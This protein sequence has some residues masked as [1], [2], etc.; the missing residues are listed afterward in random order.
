MTPNLSCLSSPAASVLAQIPESFKLSA[1]YSL[2]FCFFLL[3]LIFPVFFSFLSSFMRFESFEHACE[4]HIKLLL[5]YD[6][7]KSRLLKQTLWIQLNALSCARVASWWCICSF[8]DWRIIS[9]LKKKNLF[10]Y[11]S[12]FIDRQPRLIFAHLCSFSISSSVPSFLIR[13]HAPMLKLTASYVL[14][15]S[16]R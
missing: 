11:W 9:T 3:F 6:D 7:K 10:C 5:V 16:Y 2:C 15:T 14:G 1:S 4:V 8:L 13:A 12:F